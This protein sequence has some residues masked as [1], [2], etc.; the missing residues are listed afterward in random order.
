MISYG[1]RFGSTVAKADFELAVYV[2]IISTTKY[3]LDFVTFADL[4]K[5]IKAENSDCETHAKRV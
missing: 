5:I 4:I 1:P 2:S 3:V